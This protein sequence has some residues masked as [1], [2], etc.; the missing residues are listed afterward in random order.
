MLKIFVILIFVALSDAAFG[1]TA[2]ESYIQLPS[3]ENAEAV[4][5]IEYSKGAIPERDT[6]R[7]EHILLLETQI[8][9]GDAAAWRLAYRLRAKSDGA[10][11]E[12]I[13]HALSRM[14]RPHP[15]IFLQEFQK[16][17]IPSESLF[18][19]LLMT[20]EEYVD[21]YDAQKYELSMRLEAIESVTDDALMGTRDLCVRILRGA[22]ESIPEQ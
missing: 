16:L 8:A 9:A 2:W 6:Y 13:N 20:G 4:E 22:I 7:F 1:Q 3:P 5:R 12:D 11:Y 18:D 14:I 21:L 15:K 10:L 17:G 19:A